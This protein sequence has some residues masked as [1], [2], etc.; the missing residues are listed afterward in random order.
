MSNSVP[1]TRRGRRILERLGL[2]VRIVVERLD[3]SAPSEAE[4]AT[5]RAAFAELDDLEVRADRAVAEAGSSPLP[6]RP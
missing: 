6:K 3:G 5:V 1:A 4:V 2:R